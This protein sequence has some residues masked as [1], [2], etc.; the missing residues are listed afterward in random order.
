MSTRNNESDYKQVSLIDFLNNQGVAER[1][2]ISINEDY[3]YC[4]QA[5]GKN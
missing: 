3:Y 4:K 5:P 1:F 2:K